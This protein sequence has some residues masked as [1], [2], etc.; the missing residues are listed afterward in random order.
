MELKVGKFTP[1]HAAQLGFYV[2]WVDDNLRNAQT[3]LPTVGILLVA[4]RNQRVVRYSLAG[5]AA[6][7]AVASYASLPPAVRQLVPTDE[8]LTE[9]LGVDLPE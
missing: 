1:E 5:A 6:P 2:A 7:L 9:A 8:Q 4:G 3:H